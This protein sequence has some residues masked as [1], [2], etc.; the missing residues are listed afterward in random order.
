[1]LV[2][3]LGHQG[4]GDLQQERPGTGAEQERG[5]AVE[6][7]G[8]GAGAVQPGALGIE[9]ARRPEVLDGRRRRQRSLGRRPTTHQA[10][11]KTAAAASSL[12]VSTTRNGSIPSRT[13][14]PND[15][16]VVIASHGTPTA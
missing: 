16:P 2:D 1:M 4:M 5:L 9:G 10:A 6:A 3:A 13:A 11:G 12:M 14:S 15:M 8:L 7:P